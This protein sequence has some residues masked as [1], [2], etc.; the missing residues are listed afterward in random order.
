M[1][2]SE[3]EL[4]QMRQKIQSHQNKLKKQKTTEAEEQDPPDAAKV[5]ETKDKD[6]KVGK[7]RLGWTKLPATSHNF[8]L[9]LMYLLSQSQYDF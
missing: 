6:D 7:A 8:S 5:L 4:E 3:A 2:Q 1:A 9:Y